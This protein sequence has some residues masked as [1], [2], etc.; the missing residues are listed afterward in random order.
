M[1]KREE[2]ILKYAADLKDKFNIDADMELLMKIAIGCGPSI[3]NP[4]S[5]TVSSSDPSELETVK[6]KFLIRKLGLNDGPELD[7]SIAMVMDQYGKTNRTKYRVVVYYLL[8]THFG[9]ASVY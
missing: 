1:N 5:S 2:L 8:T 3:Y 9:K 7:E 4:D 6:Q